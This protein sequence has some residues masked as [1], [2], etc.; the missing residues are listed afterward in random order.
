MGS[1]VGRGKRYLNGLDVRH[2][3]NGEVDVSKGS[4]KGH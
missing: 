2:P 3:I 1:F 4:V